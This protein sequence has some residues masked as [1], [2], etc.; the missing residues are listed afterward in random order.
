MGGEGAGDSVTPE[1]PPYPRGRAVRGTHLPLIV[2]GVRGLRTALRPGGPVG[3]GLQRDGGGH[4]R[5][6]S[7]THAHSPQPHA[8]VPSGTMRR[9]F[10]PAPSLGPP[11]L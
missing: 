3:G 8:H 4:S 1:H 2:G 9:S 6:R 11:S 10:S 7:T 5:Q